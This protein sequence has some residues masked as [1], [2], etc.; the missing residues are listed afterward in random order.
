MADT[1]QEA[2]PMFGSPIGSPAAPQPTFAEFAA[3]SEG[4]TA[5]NGLQ[6]LAQALGQSQQL[7]AQ[8]NNRMQTHVAMEQGLLQVQFENRGLR[9]D[10]ETAQGRRAD[11]APT[12]RTSGSWSTMS[13]DSA[14]PVF[15]GNDRTV[16]RGW[17][18]KL[19]L[20]AMDNTYVF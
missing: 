10:S 7:A 2:Q 4:T 16:F 1:A 19:E 6:C 3:S 11:R 20:C 18:F 14:P 17:A 13:K 9:R 5:D 15:D 12:D 8:N